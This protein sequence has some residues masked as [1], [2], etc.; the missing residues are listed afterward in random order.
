M[1]LNPLE[2]HGASAADIDVFGRSLTEKELGLPG[3]L[4]SD[5]GCSGANDDFC[6]AVA[7]SVSDT[8]KFTCALRAPLASP[9]G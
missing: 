6:Q 2:E 4:A 3:R 9:E 8:D 1:P 7:E 5:H